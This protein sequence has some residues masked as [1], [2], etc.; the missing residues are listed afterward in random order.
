MRTGERNVSAYR[1]AEQG[2]DRREDILHRS[3]R[4]N[5]LFQRKAYRRPNNNDHHEDHDDHDTAQDLRQRIHG[6]QRVL[7]QEDDDRKTPGDKVSRHL[8]DAQQGIESKG[9]SAHISNVKYQAS[10]NDEERHYVAKSG[11][12]LV[13]HVLPSH[14]GYTEHTP[15]R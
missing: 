11:K 2:Q 15:I 3:G 10:C 9:A 14:A 13:R 5:R 7:H 8:R 1:T 12:D 4:H 6:I